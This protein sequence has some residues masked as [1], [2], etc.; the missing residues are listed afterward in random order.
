MEEFGTDG[1]FDFEVNKGRKYITDHFLKIFGPL[2]TISTFLILSTAGIAAW[3]AVAVAIGVVVICEMH[4]KRCA[5]KITFDFE[6]KTV[7]F[8]LHRAEAPIRVTFE[9]IKK[10][11]TNNYLLFYTNGGKIFF[12]DTT[13]KR[14]IIYASR[15]RPLTWGIFSC[16]GNVKRQEVE[17]VAARQNEI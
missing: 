12:K 15:I 5:W 2:L 4:N 11:Y 6:T 3:P 8:F 1:I 10:I 17:A 16:L 14:S 9:E 7:T 13:D